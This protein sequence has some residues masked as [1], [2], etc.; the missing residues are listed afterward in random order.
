MPRPGADA[1]REVPDRRRYRTGAPANPY[2][3][4][5]D[6]VALFCGKPESRTTTVVAP[7]PVSKPVIDVEPPLVVTVDGFGVPDVGLTL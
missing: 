3:Q 6:P 1:Y 4:V 7:L 5:I 2:E